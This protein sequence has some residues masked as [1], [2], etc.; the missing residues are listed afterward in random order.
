MKRKIKKK[1]E[2]FIQVLSQEC[3]NL[4]DKETIFVADREKSLTNAI[5]EKLPSATIINCWNY[6]KKDVKEWLKKRKTPQSNTDEY[7]ENLD[8]LLRC[9]P[10]DHFVETYDKLSRP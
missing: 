4:K 5:S 8:T 6:V 9:T 7:F 10:S 3:P 1:Q 2:R